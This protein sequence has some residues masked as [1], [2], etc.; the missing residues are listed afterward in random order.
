MHQ[1]RM[2][3]VDGPTC[4]DKRL[5]QVNTGG[6]T[7]RSFMVDLLDLHNGIRYCIHSDSCAVSALSVSKT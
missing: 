4:A 7:S 5:H 1:L 3:T 6:I 2:N